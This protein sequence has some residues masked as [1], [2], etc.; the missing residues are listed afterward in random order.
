MQWVGPIATRIDLGPPAPSAESIE[1]VHVPA[2][3]DK[4]FQA[5]I[6]NG[7]S[8]HPMAVP[9]DVESADRLELL[10]CLPNGWPLGEEDI[11]GHAGWPIRLLGQIAAFPLLYGGWLGFG[12][13]LPNGD[14]AAPYAEDT[15]QSCALI[16]PPLTMMPEFINTVLPSGR[17]V[18]F[19]AVVPIYQI[20][21]D[22]KVEKGVN[23]L[24]KRFDRKGVNEVINPTRRSVAGTLL[25]IL[26][27]N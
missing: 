18:Q 12:H 20:E 23:E 15:E 16:L 3:E 13:T 14:P 1:I 27:N 21:A 22:L 17:P 24:L 8:A 9:D 7:M 25:E 2:S 19:L 5:L 11:K 10:C 26:D 6:T 4:P